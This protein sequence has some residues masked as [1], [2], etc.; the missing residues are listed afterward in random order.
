M[1][2]VRPRTI[3]R[4]STDTLSRL[5][6]GRVSAEREG[7]G[8]RVSFVSEKVSHEDVDQCDKEADR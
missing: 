8:I 3:I 6:S 1:D 5:I 2:T 4:K 7:S